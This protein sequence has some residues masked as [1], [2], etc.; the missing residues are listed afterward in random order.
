MAESN[1]VIFPSHQC[2]FELSNRFGHFFLEKIENIRTNLLSASNAID[3]VNPLRADIR[4]EGNILTE[5]RPASI[6]EV[7]K[8]ILK[9]QSK[10]C[11][12]DPIP[13][14]LLKSCV[15]NIAMNIMMIINKSLSTSV[16]PTSYKE[17]IV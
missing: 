16:V 9:A 17:A 14:T 10:A 8:I 6:D 4:F 2:K 7:T 15:N 13:T 11:E 1:A 12:L 3:D 5:I